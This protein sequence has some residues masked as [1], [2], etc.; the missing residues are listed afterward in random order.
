MYRLNRQHCYLCDLPRTPWAMIYDFSETVCRGCVNYE[1][2]DRI[3]TILENARMLRRTSLIDRSNNFTSSKTLLPI[4]TSFLPTN[5]I[6]YP[7]KSLSNGQ[8]R[9]STSF[10]N[11]PSYLSSSS[12]PSN[13]ATST[14][15]PDDLSLPELVKDSLRLLTSSTPFDIRLKRDPTIQARLFLFDSH[16]RHT[17]TG[18]S[19]EYELRIFSEYPIGSSNVH[20]NINSL[21][22]QMNA[23]V[24][25]SPSTDDNQSIKNPYKALEYRIKSTTTDETINNWHL[26]NDL[27]HERV[28]SFKE[29]PNKN[30]LP[31]IYLDLKQTKLPSIR[32]TISKR[33]HNDNDI[34]S[35]NKYR[36]SKRLR[37]HQQ[38]NE[39]LPT[40]IPL[41]ILQCS[42]CHQALEDTHFVQCPSIS[43]HRY[44]FLCCKNFIK[45]QTG[46]KEI[47]CPSGLKCPLVGSTNVPW[48]FM[49]TEIETILNTRS[50]SPP[51][52]NSPSTLTIKQETEI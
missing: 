49:R 37:T 52:I 44:C 22:R 8:H 18:G 1:G 31:E 47:Y 38:I 26:L 39:S 28:R 4:S 23:D 20:A 17:S 12:S 46:E 13:E 11:R 19:N 48:A 41:L 7:Y 3:E 29:L 33:K 50:P 25:Q 9:I 51:K 30:L 24:K 6:P 21:Y 34:N 32:Q 36:L 40:S 14:Q 45:K 43:E 16:Q 10:N 15:E 35:I 5:G 42:E 2:A 27:L